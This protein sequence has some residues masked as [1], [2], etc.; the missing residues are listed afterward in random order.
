M[1]R[2][3]LDVLDDLSNHSAMTTASLNWKLVDDLA[4]ALGA[5][6]AARLKWRQGGRG[7]PPAWRIRIAE[8]ARAAGNPIDFAAFDALPSTPGRL[9]QAA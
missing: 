5:G 3:V 9:E 1:R 6:E 4:A 8:A 2:F 7:V